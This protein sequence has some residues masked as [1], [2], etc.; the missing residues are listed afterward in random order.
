MNSW[1]RRRWSS[2]ALV[3]AGTLAVAT[4]PVPAWAQE[5]GDW[6]WGMHPMSWM[7]GAWG[8]GMVVMMLVFWGVV[9]I[10]AV[11]A[12]RWLAGQGDRSRSDRALDILRE[13]Y[14]RGEINKDEFEAKQ[15]DL[16]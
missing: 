16:R 8:L 6:S 13:R 2:T 15:R 12:I 1:S 5:R 10:G 9:I 3:L 11:L 4:T 14:A 7:W